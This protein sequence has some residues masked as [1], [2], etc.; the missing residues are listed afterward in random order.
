MGILT[1]CREEPKQADSLD[2][3]AVVVRTI[4]PYQFTPLTLYI[5]TI[6]WADW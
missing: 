5:L 4:K 3:V 1:I 2:A 6:L